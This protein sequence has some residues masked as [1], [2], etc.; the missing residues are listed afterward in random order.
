MHQVR[1]GEVNPYTPLNHKYQQNRQP[2]GLECKEQYQNNKYDGKDTDHHIIPTEGAGKVE[3]TGAVAYQQ[4]IVVISSH[5]F[6][7][8][9]Q[10]CESFLA[11]FRQIQIQYQTGVI[12]PLQLFSGVVDF[13]I[14]VVQIPLHFIIQFHISFVRFFMN[15]QKH[16]NEGHFVIIQIPNDITIFLIL[17]AVSTIKE[18]R[19]FHIQV[20]HFRKFS[21]CQSVCQH[22]V[23]FRFRIGNTQSRIHFGML[24]Y[25][26]QQRPL[27]AII[28][29]G[30]DNCQCILSPKGFF[31]LIICNGI[32]ALLE[33]S[34]LCIPI[35]IRAHRRKLE[36]HNQQNQEN[37]RDDILH[38]D[39]NPSQSINAWYKVFMMCLVNALAE[40][41]QQTGHQCKYRQ[42]TAKDSFDEHTPH[43]K[44]NAE[45]HE[46]Q[47]SQTGNG[48]QAA[49]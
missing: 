46:H 27:A 22:I 18:F 11:F 20:H 49:G 44:P 47:R 8:H 6:S 1:E 29:F 38:F 14:C 13:F 16:I 39:N 31:D 43:I 48:G 7:K 25:I 15:K 19:H 34:N 30:N 45:L 4:K 5:I 9:I 26:C 41:H 35:S 23:I 32:L 3:V 21:G 33:R 36:R 12:F 28:P 40:Q 2:N 10:E 24:L 42:Q 17:D 37:R